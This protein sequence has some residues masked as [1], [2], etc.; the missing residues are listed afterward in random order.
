MK[1]QSMMRELNL[2]RTFMKQFPEVEGRM[3]E[4]CEGSQTRPL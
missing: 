1:K 3:Q 4:V 2:T